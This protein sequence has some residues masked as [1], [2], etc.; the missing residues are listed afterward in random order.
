MPK[1]VL[2]ETLPV[3]SVARPPVPTLTVGV[4]L[5]TMLPP[6]LV[7]ALLPRPAFST[8]AVALLS[9][10]LTFCDSVK[11]P[12]CVVML[13]TPLAVMPWVPSTLP[14]A[15]APL[16]TRRKLPTPLAAK[17]PMVLLL[18]LKATLPPSKRRLLAVTLPS[19]VT[20]PTPCS[21]RVEPVT[22]KAPLT[23]MPPPAV[24]LAGP[25][26]LTA[27][28]L[29]LL[30]FT[31]VRPLALATDNTPVK[32]LPAL[33]SAT[34]PAPAFRLV[35]PATL[36]KPLWVMLP[37]PLLA[38]K[39]PSTEEVLRLSAPVLLSVKLPVLVA[40][41]RL[42]A[43]ASAMF[44]LAPVRETAP[45]KSLPVLARVMLAGSTGLEPV[46]AVKLLVL[47]A[48]MAA[49]TDCTMAPPALFTL[50]APVLLRL[51]NCT[52]PLVSVMLVVP[53]TVMVPLVP[54]LK[55]V[56]TVRSLLANRVPPVCVRLPMF[57]APVLAKLPSDCVKL[58]SVVLPALVKMP[59]LWL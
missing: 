44:T 17:V 43:L 7:P 45:V 55:L 13:T 9:V 36:R 54:W 51:P 25:A 8:K 33:L 22:A 20:L 16:L 48:V 6:V 1:P 14:R 28:K 58:P 52:P 49:P 5:T 53:I 47:P 11:L 4:P 18:P 10:V 19:T 59:P 2:P 29:R 12:V 27:P 3:Y 46:D 56:V 15:S 24:T 35:V 34:L 26:T 40:V 42:S 21:V 39:L 38:L 23:A 57:M 31:S 30:P 37:P 41:P 32:S 50:K